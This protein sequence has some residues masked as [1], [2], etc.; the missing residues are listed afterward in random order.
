MLEMGNAMRRSVRRS[1]SIWKRSY[2]TMQGTGVINIV[3][4]VIITVGPGSRCDGDRQ[5]CVFT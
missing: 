5:R 2:K 1:G 4:E 3:I